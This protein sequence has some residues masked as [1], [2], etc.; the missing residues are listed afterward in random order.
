MAIDHADEIRD[1][2][3]QLFIDVGDEDCFHLHNAAELM[4]RTMW[5]LRIPH[6]Y[7]L[8]RGANHMGSSWR[9]RG[10]EATNPKPETLKP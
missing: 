6:E 3:I 8:V 5:H 2:G 1:S 10:P 9:R 7:H 4:H